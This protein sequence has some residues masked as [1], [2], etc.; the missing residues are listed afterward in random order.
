M[1][2]SLCAQSSVR[3]ALAMKHRV[4]Y[5]IISLIGGTGAYLLFYV[6]LHGTRLGISLISNGMILVGAAW[7]G[8]LMWRDRA[9]FRQLLPPARATHRIVWICLG[10]TAVIGLVILLD[11]R[12][13]SQYIQRSDWGVNTSFGMYVGIMLF[14]SV[15]SVP[16]QELIF[17]GYFFGIIDR[18]WHRSEITVIG[19]AGLYA[20]AHYQYGWLAVGAV[21]LF[22]LVLGIVM[23]RTKKLEI[24]IYLHLAVGLGLVAVNIIRTLGS[25]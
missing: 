4:V 10:L 5:F 7:T 9:V 19:T 11:Q 8:W 21:F 17:R 12:A 23:L 18:L 14:Y 15:L 24:P 2:E 3:G 25:G 1:T 22:G 13:V 6:W 16:L 20:I